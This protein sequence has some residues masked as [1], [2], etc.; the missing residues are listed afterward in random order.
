MPRL[1]DQQARRLAEQVRSGERRER[2][3]AVST[4]IAFVALLVCGGATIYVAVGGDN[5]SKSEKSE[6]FIVHASLNAASSLGDF[7]YPK[8]KNMKLTSLTSLSKVSSVA[9]AA[10][11]I[12]IGASAQDAVQWRVEDGGNG[13]WYAVRIGALMPFFDREAEVESFGAHLA[14]V[15]SVGEH[16]AVFAIVD[17]TGGFD[18][19]PWPALGGYRLADESAWQWVTGEAFDGYA[20]WAPGEPNAP[21]NTSAYIQMWGI[22][23][24]PFLTFDD[25]QNQT[26]NSKVLCEWESDCNADGIVD[27]GQCRDGSLPDFNGNNVPDCCERSEPCVEG[28][29]PVQWRVQDGGNGHWY[30]IDILDSDIPWLV[31][32]DLSLS[33]GGHLATISSGPE[34]ACVLPLLESASDSEDCYPVVYIGLTLMSGEDWRWI[35]GSPLT[36]SIWGQVGDPVEPQGM[37]AAFSPGGFEPYCVPHLKWNDAAIDARHWM[38]RGVFIEWSADC[39]A[40]GIVDYG[41]ILGGDLA[42]SNSDGVPDLCQCPADITRNNV[43]DA[44]DLAVLLGLWGTAGQGEFDADT[45]SDG[46]VDGVDL[47]VVMG[48]WGQC[49]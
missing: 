31:A 12:C 13:H 33:L 40:D 18:T 37:M 43:V 49:P 9:I 1:P 28:N 17:A 2:L 30:R 34:Y 38:H 21:T 7:P 23:P 35:D 45:N 5:F 22:N 15:T 27:Y 4:R 11:G 24:T 39:N 10:S 46:I 19:F 44:V 41:Q 36:W 26:I 47:A 48:G 42:D 14:A 6:T 29:Y 8:E 16:Q 32:R 25:N 20:P 3:R